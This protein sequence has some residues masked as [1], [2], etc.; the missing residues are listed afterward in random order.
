MA[1][2]LDTR[3]PSGPA[4]STLGR[5]VRQAGIEDIPAVARITQEGP[6]RTDL[7]PESAARST[8]LL[9]THIAFER[10]ALWVE[11]G[12]DGRIARAVAVVPGGQHSPWETV[13]RVVAPDLAR[14]PP[15]PD[16][17][18]A[19]RTELAAVA[20]RWVLSEISQGSRAR[21]G[22]PTLLEAALSW[23]RAEPGWRHGPIAVVADTDAERKAAESLGFAE[24]WTGG[25]PSP[26]W[27]GVDT[28]PVAPGQA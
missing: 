24:R 13:G 6:L 19:F 7:D 17:D 20:P 15:G 22:P 11:D 25:P 2:P 8:R 27:L 12:V 26:W 5:S 16:A 9:L 3:S 4:V 18:Q 28:D 23:A 10:G 21:P 14:V 1:P